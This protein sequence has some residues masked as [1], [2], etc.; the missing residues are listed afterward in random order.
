[1]F[2][3]QRRLP[4]TTRSDPPKLTSPLVAADAD[5]AEGDPHQD[6]LTCGVC[7]KPFAL[8]D[9]V[10]FIQHKVTACNKE[11]FGQCYPATD[12]DRDNDDGALPLSTIN[13]RRPSISAPI[14]GKKSAGSRVHTPPP[15]SPRLPAPGDLCV[16][17]AASSTPKRRASSPLT[18]SSL[19][20]DIK[21]NIKQEK[22]DTTMSPEENSCK[23]SRT[24][25]ADAESNTTHSGKLI[26]FSQ[27]LY[28]EKKNY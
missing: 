12:R 20:E 23:R 8:S 10:R 11:N 27:F 16:D 2:H 1:M 19:E 13:T 17:G 14:S 22:M 6:I 15:A 3:L 25:V 4:K 5:G 7:Q 28:T 9:I 18:S 24:E 26:M 21:P